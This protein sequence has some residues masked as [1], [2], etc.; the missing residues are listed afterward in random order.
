MRKK[1]KNNSSG[2]TLVE[3][4]IVAGLMGLVAVF[5]TQLTSNMN[6]TLNRMETRAAEQEL[7]YITRLALTNK[8][9]CSRTIGHYCR[10]IDSSV[11]IDTSDDRD[12]PPPG[13]VYIP[14]S[15][16]IPSNKLEWVD[17]NS[18]EIK[19][20]P[21]GTDFKL[22]EVDDTNSTLVT[23]EVNISMLPTAPLGGNKKGYIFNSSYGP[24]FRSCNELT[25]NIGGRELNI[26]SNCNDE[27]FY[28]DRKIMLTQF[29]LTNYPESEGGVPMGGG[30]GKVKF[31]FEYVRLKENQRVMRK[32]ID[33]FVQT[34][35][36]NIVESCLSGSDVEVF[37]EDATYLVQGNSI[38]PAGSQQSCSVSCGENT[39]TT[40]LDQ[41][42]SYDA[43]FS[44][45]LSFI[46]C[47]M[48]LAQPT[49]SAGG[50]AVCTGCAASRGDVVSGSCDA[51]CKSQGVRYTGVE[52]LN[53]NP[54]I[55]TTTTGYTNMTG[56][57]AVCI[58][59]FN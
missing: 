50:S 52:C 16:C 41:M 13:N 39:E 58:K 55:N 48:Q 35:S 8:N 32:S 14:Q 19:E 27:E 46:S 20:W 44:G 18:F 28:V 51:E 12:F 36:D 9:A 23:H 1:L 29:Y 57:R 7:L 38:A 43:L 45:D 2:F 4:V 30:L 21:S 26:P 17:D 37:A 25:L 40:L 10:T 15:N 47:D 11:D 42:V 24:V 5:V 33:L 31:V 6:M 59:R 49:T 54:T 3:V 34:D 22:S 56:C 53:S